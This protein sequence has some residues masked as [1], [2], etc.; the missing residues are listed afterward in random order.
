MAGGFVFRRG[1][2][3]A[4]I[5][6]SQFGTPG[7]RMS[8]LRGLGGRFIKKG[9]GL[10]PASGLPGMGGLPGPMMRLGKKRRRIRVTNV[11][12]LRRGIRRLA[13]FERLARRVLRITSPTKK[14]KVAGFKKTAKRR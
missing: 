13:G 11:K 5:G 7:S 8:R 2:K 3:T 10:F 6:S 9:V 14:F 12:A 4:P 1:A